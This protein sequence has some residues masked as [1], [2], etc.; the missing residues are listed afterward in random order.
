MVGGGV[1]AVKLSLMQD[2]QI[3]KTILTVPISDC[4]ISLFNPRGT[5]T[6]EEIDR[7]AE[8]IARNG[9]EIT[10]ALWA[11]QNEEGYAVFAGGSRLE[12]AQRA[13][14]DEVPIILH[15]GLTDEDKVRLAEQDN[16]NDEY[17]EPVC[18]VDVWAHYA[19]LSEQGWIQ[20][21]IA[22]AKGLRNHSLV[23]VRIK[24]H[25]LPSTVKQ[26]VIQGDIEE[27]HLREISSLLLEA[28]FSDWLVTEQVQ[29]ELVQ[30]AVKD[31]SKNGSKSVKAVK[32]DVKIWRAFIEEAEN[33]YADFAKDITLYSLDESPPTP[34]LFDAQQMFIDEL[35]EREARTI[36]VVK[37]AAREVKLFIKHNLEDYE[38]YVQS[39]SAEAAQKA[40][41]AQRE[42]ELLAKY[43]K[44][45][46]LDVLADWQLGEI[47]LLLIDP[48]YGK[49]YK[50]NRR[51]ASEAPDVIAGDDEHGAMELLTQ[52]LHEVVS[53]FSD[54]T[55][56]LIFCDWKREPEARQI[57]EGAGLK[58]KGSLI[59]TKE[60]HTAG[61]LQGSFGPSHERIIHAV[62][63]SP[64]VTPRIRDVLGFSRS[65]DTS[66]PNEKPIK[67]LTALINSTT[68]EGDLVVDL[69]AGC[70][71]TLV[72]AMKLK[73]EF[74]GVEI[75][76]KYHEEGTARL[77]KEY[78]D[79][80]QGRS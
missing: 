31:K 69:F 55:H 76:D 52:A 34:Y 58:L 71:S 77:L 2:E 24:L 3:K 16:E 40:I 61:D 26:F 18:P 75:D 9:F 6:D 73:R 17:H 36:T 72:A 67:L 14:L 43:V 78:G 70:A 65:K 57:I 4:T 45:D 53:K 21:R 37:A 51:W 44:G 59:W 30:K 66:H 56:V 41:E 49:E 20:E 68:N 63:G 80:L 74:F 8:R 47:Q 19:W 50:T 42:A 15:E 10:R 48:P 1:M 7:L 79:V 5:R 35:R 33:A 39:E 12:A 62:K 64:K 46:C 25:R 32:A 11:Y 13:A 27:A 22:R 29:F 28:Q 23:S 60:E 38:T 54:D